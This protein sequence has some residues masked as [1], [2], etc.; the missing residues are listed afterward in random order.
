MC[1]HTL[2]ICCFIDDFLKARPLG[3]DSRQG[4]Y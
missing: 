4:K 2:A 1:G 3:E